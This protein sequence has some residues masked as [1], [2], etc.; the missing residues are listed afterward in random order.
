MRTFHVFVAG[1]LELEMAGCAS[2][3]PPKE[4]IDARVTYR[5]A[6]EGRAGQYDPAGV[7]A[8]EDALRAAEEAFQSNG[9]AP[10]TRDLAYV[11]ARQAEIAEARAETFRANQHVEI[12]SAEMAEAKDKQLE[13]TQ[14]E[15]ARRD[16]ALREEQRRLEEGERS[17]RKLA[18]ELGR[19][20]TTTYEARGI[21]ITVPGDALF[22]TSTTILLPDAWERL[23]HIANVLRRTDPESPIV[24]QCFTDAN[25]T[26]AV[27]QELSDA[28][29][30]RLRNYFTAHGIDAER[31]VAQG[32]GANSPLGD[33]RTAAGRALNRR[34]EIVVA[35]KPAPGVSP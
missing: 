16:Q 11:A 18:A 14:R 4:L 32:K 20:A 2:A 31:I 34:V 1:I 13:A 8:A 9:D 23:W 29:A 22:A 5:E 30:A 15:I 24:V 19:L 26:D 10:E 12:T 6:A 21:V 33:N 17:A 27:N 3:P 28:R 35:P 25:G 7:R